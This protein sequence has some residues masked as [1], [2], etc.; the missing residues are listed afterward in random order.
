[1]LI[2]TLFSSALFAIDHQY[3]LQQMDHTYRTEREKTS[4]DIHITRDPWISEGQIYPFYQLESKSSTYFEYIFSPFTTEQ[5][6]NLEKQLKQDSLTQCRKMS[7]EEYTY[8]YSLYSKDEYQLFVNF[9]H[10]QDEKDT[11]LNDENVTYL[12]FSCLIQVK[13]AKKDQI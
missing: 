1:M 4:I 12:K 5:G 3:A 11:F 7:E 6:K 9:T 8:Q 13:L 10:K 2:F